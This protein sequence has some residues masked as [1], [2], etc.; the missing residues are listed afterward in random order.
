M[1]MPSLWD[2]FP[3][4]NDEVALTYVLYILFYKDF[5]ISKV[6][7]WSLLRS[8]TERSWLALWG[9]ETDPRS[10][11]VMKYFGQKSGWAANSKI[12][13]VHLQNDVSTVLYQFLWYT[14]CFDIPDW[15][16][17]WKYSLRWKLGPFTPGC[18]ENFY[19]SAGT[20]TLRVLTV[21]NWACSFY[22]RQLKHHSD[23]FYFSF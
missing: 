9:Q 5:L 1:R 23:E 6:E 12:P 21:R 14:F 4:Y 20:F 7:C 22:L 17:M 18:G 8:G 11:H 2:D 3:S 19:W 16:C 13:W 15:G 10:S